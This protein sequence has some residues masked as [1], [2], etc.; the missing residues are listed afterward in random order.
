MLGEDRSFKGL[1][2]DEAVEYKSAEF[3]AF[4]LLALPGVEQ[5]YDQEESH[6]FNGLIDVQAPVGSAEIEILTPA[7]LRVVSSDVKEN[8]LEQVEKDEQA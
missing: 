7:W 3:F 1:E 8:N 4:L 6:Q 5:V 2:V